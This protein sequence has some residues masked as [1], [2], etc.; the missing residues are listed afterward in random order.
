MLFITCYLTTNFLFTNISTV[1][2]ALT[3]NEWYGESND[4][5]YYETNK[6]NIC[7]FKSE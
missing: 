7:G 5:I 2:P 3:I 4:L 6:L 1:P